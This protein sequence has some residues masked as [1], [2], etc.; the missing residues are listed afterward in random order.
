MLDVRRWIIFLLLMGLLLMAASPAFAGEVHNIGSGLYA[1]ISSNDSSANSTFLVSDAGILV[2]D[3]GLNETEGKKL[4]AE[5][6]KISAAPVRWIVN[7][8]Y[9]PDH[10]GGNSVFGA[11]ATIIDTPFTRDHLSGGTDQAQKVSNSGLNITLQ[12]SVTLFVGGHRVEI[13]HPGRHTQW[14]I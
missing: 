8:H 11:D 6:R 5:I 7:T 9:H 3:T 10:R 2:V 13:Y 4:L 14:A 12:T 1:Y